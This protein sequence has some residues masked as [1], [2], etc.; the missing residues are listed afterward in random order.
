MVF[1]L[2]YEVLL[3][4]LSPL[5]VC[6][7]LICALKRSRPPALAARFGFLSTGDISRISGHDIIW[8]HA[9]SVGETMAVKSL[10]KEL[11]KRYPDSKIILSNVTETGRK[12]ALQLPEIDLCIYFPF[13]FRLAVRKILRSINPNLV[14]IAETELWPN[15]LRETAK[16]AIPLVLVNGRISDRSFVRYKKLE[17]AFSD[18]LKFFSALCM[19][20][21]EDGRRIK[22]LGADPARVHVAGNLKYDIPVS[23]L[24]RH[25][26]EAVR[27][28]YHIPASVTV[29]TAGSTHQGEDELILRAYQELLKENDDLFLVLAP[30]HPERAGKVGELLQT[31]GLRYSLR[32]A[33]NE[34]TPMFE[35]GEVLL[36][37]TVGELTKV[38]SLSDV[39]F[40]G[41]S[42]VPVGGHNILEPASH[43]VPVLFGPFMNNF[44][45]IESL[46]LQNGGGIKVADTAALVDSVRMLLSDEC[47]R[48]EM[49]MNGAN[50]LR[51]NSG[52]T[53]RHMEIISSFL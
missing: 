46:V 7:H 3:I 21:E 25:N 6:W 11:R 18:V 16:R 23:C 32:S 5:I 17:W 30:R 47:K 26:V 33:L 13:D 19:Q 51:R 49:G 1:Y 14:I 41:G 27:K 8:V 29:F 9:V 48:Q 24:S 12:I 40:V 10:L 53:K 44:R 28:E 43:G 50:L 15:F 39:V 22:S 42:L 38:F 20:T 35:N 37:D 45:E 34:H 31:E 2:V 4:L 36:L 52:S